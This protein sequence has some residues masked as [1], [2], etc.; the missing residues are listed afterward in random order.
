MNR[1]DVVLDQSLDTLPQLL[2]ARRVCHADRLAR[3]ESKLNPIPERLPVGVALALREQPEAE[4]TD[5]S[6]LSSPAFKK[7]TTSDASNS[8]SKVKYR[9]EYVRDQVLGAST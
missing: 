1:R 8:R 5:T 3:C 4:I 2:V 6:W 9:I 7:L